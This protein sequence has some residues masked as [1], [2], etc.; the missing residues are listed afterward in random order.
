MFNVIPA[1]D[2]IG[3]KVVR[4]TQGDYG[5]VTHYDVTPAQLAKQ[6]EDNGAKRIH[7]VD[8]DGAKDGALVNLDT[9]KAIRS[10]VSC[11]LELGGGIRTKNAVSQM[12]EIG[13]DFVILGS[14]LV[15]NNVLSSE[16]I[17]SFPGKIVAGLDT[18]DGM[19]ATEG[20][21]EKSTVSVRDVLD[22]L[23]ESDLES[24]IYT[25]IAK[26]GMMEG[27]NIEALKDVSGITDIPIIASGG[28]RNLDDI[29]QLKAFSNRGISGCIIGKAIV[30]GQLPLDQI[31]I[32]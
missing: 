21:I 22:T 3:G 23:P 12:I 28:V 7:L 15:K 8:L 14:L 20:W 16:I 13:I 18:K 6:F 19:V 29:A 25:D 27:P 26:D 30:S 31:W 11:E 10:A 32:D 5:R 9:F 1:I 4:L 2:I 24:I 17:S